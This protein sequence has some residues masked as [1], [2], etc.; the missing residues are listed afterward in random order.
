MLYLSF[1]ENED[2]CLNE[3]KLKRDITLY[4]ELSLGCIR[5]EKDERASLLGLVFFLDLRPRF[6]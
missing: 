6:F 5:K 4:E 2:R 1:L 3:P